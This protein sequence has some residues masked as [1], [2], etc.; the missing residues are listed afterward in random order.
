MCNESSRLTVGL[1]F[2]LEGTIGSRAAAFGRPRVDT[3][4]ESRIHSR[5]YPLSPFRCFNVLVAYSIRHFCRDDFE[6]L[7]RIDQ[8][9]FAP[10]ISYSRPELA[11]YMRLPGSFTLVAQSDRQSGVDNAMTDLMVT[12]PEP[13]A[14]NA[15]QERAFSAEIQ[16][17]RAD[18]SPSAG[19]R[20]G[21]EESRKS[22][23]LG[24][25]TATVSR[26]GIGH[27]ITI[28]VLP[29]VRR[30]KVGSALL[31]AAED[32]LRAADCTT[33]RLETAVSNT[34]ALA[35]YK[36]HDYVLVKTIP[37]YYADGL[38]AFVMTKRLA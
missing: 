10:G 29:Q 16:E 11:A 2:E 26:Q 38:D 20:Q 23:I 9:C 6:T 3:L 27:V 15:E 25:V 13:A 33:V 30:L 14:L 18:N 1:S 8:Q 17:T 12:Q 4:E 37:R 21:R 34:A 22:E 5:H 28:D 7:W 32:R 35:F 24:F 36:C 19:S 31:K